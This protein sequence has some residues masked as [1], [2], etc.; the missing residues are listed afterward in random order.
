MLPKVKDEENV[1]GRLTGEDRKT[2]KG[3]PYCLTSHELAFLDRDT[4]LTVEE[5]KGLLEE[6]SEKKSQ[7]NEQEGQV[8]ELDSG[9]RMEVLK[10]PGHK[11]YLEKVYYLSVDQLAS[12]QGGL[13]TFEEIRV[14]LEAELDQ[15]D[16]KALKS[17]DPGATA[18]EI[19]DASRNEAPLERLQEVCKEA[20]LLKREA[21][22]HTGLIPFA[23]SGVW[24]GILGAGGGALAGAA[25][26]GALGTLIFPG[27]GTAA[28]AAIGGLLGTMVGGVGGALLVG[29]GVATL[30]NYRERILRNTLGRIPG[31]EKQFDWDDESTPQSKRAS[32]IGLRAEKGMNGPLVA[33]FGPGGVLGALI[34]G[35]IGTI[36]APGIGTLIGAA[37]GIPVGIVGTY[38]LAMLNKGVGALWNRAWKNRQARRVIPIT[39]EQE[40]PES[41]IEKRTTFGERFKNNFAMAQVTVPLT[42][43]GGF[44][45][46]AAIGTLVAP[47]LGTLVGGIVGAIAIG[48]V[49]GAI[50]YPLLASI[51]RKKRGKNGEEVPL[52]DPATLKANAAGGF[53]ANTLL[54]SSLGA[55]IGAGIGAIIGTFAMPGLGTVA[56]AAAGAAIGTAAGAT[57]SVLGLG[58]LLSLARIKFTNWVTRKVYGAYG[59]TE[60]HHLQE[61]ATETGVVEATKISLMTG[62]PW[63]K[64]NLATGSA[65]PVAAPF[66][67]PGISLGTALLGGIAYP[68]LRAQY[69]ASIQAFGKYK[70][71]HTKRNTAVG[72]VTGAAVGVPSG[73][74]VG[75]GIGALMGLAFG[76]PVGAAAGAIVGAFAGAV[77][78]GI[79]GLLA[80][81]QAGLS[82]TFRE[83]KQAVERRKASRN[84]ELE[85]VEPKAALGDE[86]ELGDDVNHTPI[87]EITVEDE[88]DRRKSI[89]PLEH[90]GETMFGEYPHNKPVKRH[91]RR[92]KPSDEEGEGKSDVEPKHGR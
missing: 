76:G 55:L 21:M 40:S 90:V 2:L 64:V 16:K 84:I 69:A 26:G 50:G 78:G 57:A 6:A 56:G 53:I 51:N 27:I 81:A 80:G 23:I 20:R 34:G 17:Y 52:I 39:A 36:I 1:A 45:A 59:L 66:I 35:A 10:E 63:G 74:A 41:T 68:I 37:V 65:P 4:R 8:V 25:A 33:A 18:D 75:A 71:V 88:S 12:L 3:S 79:L 29:G 89:P 54:G 24:G 19:D 7:E 49:F 87:V 44:V 92:Q 13:L 47:G 62:K 15:R 32:A 70:E 38:A 77:G 14:V 28:G 5:I 85:D 46:G 83:G 42:A 86:E 61:A 82:K 60:A 67:G 73:A 48:T 22:D 30:L 31:L 9:E 43:V 91:L 72:A 58:P 11:S